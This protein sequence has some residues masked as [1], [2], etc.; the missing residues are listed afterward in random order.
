MNK[1]AIALMAATLLCLWPLGGCGSAGVSDK[2]AD[3]AQ[4]SPSPAAQS[5]DPVQTT[6]TD[7]QPTEAATATPAPTP[8]P[9]PQGIYPEDVYSHFERVGFG[10]GTEDSPAI[11]KWTTPIRL[12]VDGHPTDGDRQA[13]GALTELLR[14]IPGMP[15]IAFVTEAGN[16]IIAFVPKNE[17][18][19]IDS[20]YNG[21][22]FAQA[23]VRLD[24]AKPSARLFIADEVVSQE[25]RDAALAAL[26]FR[27]LGL[28]A[29]P[30]Q[31]Y[32]D[33]V[34]NGN[35]KAAQPSEQDWLMLKLLYCP[36]MTPGLKPADAMPVLRTLKPG[37]GGRRASL[38]DQLSYFNEVGFYWNAG[39]KDGIASK[40][41]A[42]IK[43]QIEGDP[44]EEQR[45]LIGEYADR[46]NGISGF[47]G[48]ALVDS[49][50]SFILKF[51][52]RGEI[53]KSFPKIAAGEACGFLASRAKNGVI[54]KCQL[55][56]ATDFNDEAQARSQFLRVLV[57][58]L[59]LNFTSDTWPDSIL[60]LSVT[61]Q[62][63]SGMD[64]AMLGLLYRPDV[65]PGAKR[66]V[67]MG[68]LDSQ[69]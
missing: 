15:E 62:D 60:N 28:I 36:E 63:W 45:E 1:K 40:W 35:A 69:Q 58:S 33:S 68:M 42:P 31:K 12:E 65:K 2:D 26:L 32:A 46:L 66:A 61:A 41:S 13:L 24:D 37:T 53:I 59:G 44:T 34:L 8:S 20:G 49:G 6:A 25:D 18:K 48:I 9:A 11:S 52:K 39:A 38:E 19:K 14:A 47:P 5:G 7:A 27:G 17:G 16:F 50:G 43:L 51:G 55:G 67:I 23:F 29:D 21:K 4:V 22:D 57:W 10:G 30:E 56:I 64:W 54:T 3:A